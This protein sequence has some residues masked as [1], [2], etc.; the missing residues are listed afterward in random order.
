MIS[1]A[2]RNLTIM[3]AIIVV[4]ITTMLYVLSP[5]SGKEALVYE[6]N[7]QIHVIQSEKESLRMS[8]N[9]YAEQY[10]NIDKREQE[11][12]KL[13]IDALRD[14]KWNKLDLL[15]TKLESVIM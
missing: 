9:V 3:V 4:V 13:K 2:F 12:V 7:N 10:S 5:R 1:I 6:I 15:I 8:H 14:A 11:L